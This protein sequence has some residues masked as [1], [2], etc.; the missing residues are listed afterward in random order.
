MS[1]LEL[2]RQTVV[3]TSK[4]QR[5]IHNM[6]KN[7]TKR[8]TEWIALDNQLISV[9]EDQFSSHLELWIPGMSY[10]LGFTSHWLH[11]KVTLC[12]YAH[13]FGGSHT[14]EHV[15]QET[16]EMLNAVK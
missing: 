10:H 16:E 4:G 6:A 13:W 3:V 7:I 12:W 14:A 9:V 15:K 8:V 1:S 11:F 2:H 5:N